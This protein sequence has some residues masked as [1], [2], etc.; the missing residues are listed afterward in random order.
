MTETDHG[1]SP[2][3]ET[4]EEGLLEEVKEAA[5][6]LT[7]RSEVLQAL[8]DEWVVAAGLVSVYENLFFDAERLEVLNLVASSSPESR[9]HSAIARFRAS[10][11]MSVTKSESTPF[12][13]PCLF[14]MPS[15]TLM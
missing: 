7:K 9:T 5:D 15:L 13:W 8:E 2:E 10:V 6:R 3:T 4:L 12:C 11:I 14:T 1:P